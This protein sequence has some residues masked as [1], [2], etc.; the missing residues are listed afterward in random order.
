MYNSFI[1]RIFVGSGN[2]FSSAYN[3]SILKRVLDIVAKCIRYLTDGSVV[4][5]IFTKN[6]R[7]IENSFFYRLFTKMLNL[8]TN[9]F[10]KLNNSY[11]KIGVESIVSSNIKRLF[12]TNTAL[13]I[14]IATFALF[15][16]I[17]V[18]VNN[19]VRGLFTGRSYIAAFGLI[20]VSIIVIS[21]GEGLKDS[22]ENSIIFRLIRDIFIIDE[23]GEQW[24]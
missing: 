20:I 18:I 10:I 1:V 22:L 23:G 11:K 12:G 6:Y 7:F 5:N 24:W 16:A 17:G 21:K 8:F 19:L 3:E 9:I 14:S 2:A 13:I 4:V 15:F